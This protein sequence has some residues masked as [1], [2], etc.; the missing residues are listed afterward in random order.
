MSWL[1][2]CLLITVLLGFILQGNAA[3]IIVI[4][5]DIFQ[6]RSPLFTLFH[7]EGSVLI[8]SMYIF[9]NFL[10]SKC[11]LEFVHCRIELSSNL[12]LSDLSSKSYLYLEND[13]V[14]FCL[15]AFLVISYRK[16]FSLCNSNTGHAI[17]REAILDHEVIPPLSKLVS[18]KLTNH[19]ALV[20]LNSKDLYFK[21]A[22][23]FFFVLLKKIV[24]IS[25]NSLMIKCTKQGYSHIKQF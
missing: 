18:K 12:E 23:K 5:N 20:S 17:G 10:F 19:C 16:R 24:L 22:A 9:V 11:L 3:Q 25:I 13:N 14:I 7:V 4:I 15:R 1:V 8:I 21:K 6:A 2:R